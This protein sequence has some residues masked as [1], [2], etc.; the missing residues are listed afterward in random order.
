MA[1]KKTKRDVPKKSN[2]T[3]LMNKYIKSEGAKHVPVFSKGKRTSG[4]VSATKKG[5]SSKRK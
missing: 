5:S 2:G 4:G 1:N 3:S